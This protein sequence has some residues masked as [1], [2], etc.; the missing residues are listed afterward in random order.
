MSKPTLHTCDIGRLINEKNY[1]EIERLYRDG[2]IIDS[3][4]CNISIPEEAVKR[5]DWVLLG[6]WNSSWRKVNSNVN[7]IE[8]ALL[9]ACQLGKI[10][11]LTWFYKNCDIYLFE[12]KE[13][14]LRD[15]YH[16]NVYEWWWYQFNMDV[17]KLVALPNQMLIDWLDKCSYLPPPSDLVL[18]VANIPYL[19]KQHPALITISNFIFNSVLFKKDIWQ[20]W[21]SRRNLVGMNSDLHLFDTNLKKLV[22]VYID[23]IDTI[24]ME[25]KFIKLYEAHYILKYGGYVLVRRILHTFEGQINVKYIDNY[26]LLLHLWDN[27]RH[28]VDWSERCSLIDK[29]NDTAVLQFFFDISDELPFLYSEKA[30]DRHPPAIVVNWWIHRRDII[31]LKFTNPPLTVLNYVKLSPMGIRHLD[32]CVICFQNGNSIKMNCGHSVHEECYTI[33]NQCTCPY[34]G[35]IIECT[36][37]VEAPKA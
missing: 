23:Q 12:N 6:H 14:F 2:V 24:N 25:L 27:V 22:T 17:T 7:N 36:K 35:Q 28:R 4:Q 1:S 11:F 5:D 37:K 30:L 26:H 15:C 31:P 21:W 13:N 29:T 3:F 18:R 9:L 19:N 10:D 33:Y 32:F 34:C 20:W 16:E 8:P